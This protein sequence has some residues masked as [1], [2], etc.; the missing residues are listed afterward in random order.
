[1]GVV[2]F[3]FGMDIGRGAGTREKRGC[4]DDGSGFSDGFVSRFWGKETNMWSAA[5]AHACGAY[6][7]VVS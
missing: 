5:V 7:E 3:I 2:L 1:M 4:W 6:G